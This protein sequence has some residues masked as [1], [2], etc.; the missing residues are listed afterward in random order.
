MSHAKAGLQPGPGR[1]LWTTGVAFAVVTFGLWHWAGMALGLLIVPLLGYALLAS[2]VASGLAGAYRIGAANRITFYRALGVLILAA[3]LA[4]P[5]A[6]V[7]QQWFWASLAMAI[8]ILDGVDGYLARRLNASSDFGARFDMEVD[9]ALTMTLCLGVWMLGV[10]GAWV[11]MLGLMRYAFVAAGWVWPWVNRPLSESVRRKI[12]CVWQIASLVIAL[13]PVTP[14]SAAVWILALAL[15]L[16][17]YSFTVDL[18]WLYRA[19]GHHESDGH[20]TE[21]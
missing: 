4:D 17:A 6:A 18:A 16:L 5:Y 2:L 7:S 10:A 19:G 3:G 11:L 1:E 8:L 9:A 12:I 13:L 20:G 15:A 14:A 21:T